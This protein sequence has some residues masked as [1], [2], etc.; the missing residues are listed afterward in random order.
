MRALPKGISR[1]KAALNGAA[2]SC[3]K[4]NFNGLIRLKAIKGGIN[5]SGK[6]KEEVERM[7][8]SLL[9]VKVKI[10]N[11]LKGIAPPNTPDAPDAPE[12]TSVLLADKYGVILKTADGYYLAVKS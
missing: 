12:S 9:D 11:T 6:E 10:I 3:A 4:F 5:G 8:F 2:F 1:G 7:N